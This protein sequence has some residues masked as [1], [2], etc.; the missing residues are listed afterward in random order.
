MTNDQKGMLSQSPSSRRLLSLRRRNRHFIDS[1][2]LLGPA[3]VVEQSVRRPAEDAIGQEQ[4]LD[5]SQPLV[6]IGIPLRAAR[7]GGAVAVQRARR[8]ISEVALHGS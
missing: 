7:I 5:R 3:V 2:K 1:K 4:R 8:H 6:G